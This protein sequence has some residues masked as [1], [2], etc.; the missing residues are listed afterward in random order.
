MRRVYL[1]CLAAASFAALS[2]AASPQSVPRGP[3]VLLISIDG[4]H[5]DNVLEADRHGLKVPTLRRLLREGA[6]ATAVRG[7]LP[8][9]TYPSHTTMLTG[10][11]PV[12]IVACE[13]KVSG[14]QV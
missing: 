14:A 10:Q 2:P 6:H 5:P 4:M 13:G 9:V 7:V 3:A 1:A 11:T 8:T 12:S